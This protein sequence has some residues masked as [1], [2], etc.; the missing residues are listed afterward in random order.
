MA[1]EVQQTRVWLFRS[2]DDDMIISR[3]LSDLC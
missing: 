2:D 3:G 1:L